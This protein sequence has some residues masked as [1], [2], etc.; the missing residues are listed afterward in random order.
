ME[1]VDADAAGERAAEGAGGTQAGG[2]AARED[3]VPGEGYATGTEV[4]QEEPIPLLQPAYFDNLI[5]WLLV[6]LVAIFLIL[7]RT[8]LPRVSGILAARAG[9]VAN[10]LA[11][12]ED[13]RSRAR[14]AE[15]AYVRALA[16]ARAEAGRI[17]AAARAAVQADL[18]R[19]LAEAEA[20]IAARA[21]E[22]R[23]VLDDIEAAAAVTVALVARD[24]A[25][26]IVRS[27]GIEAEEAQLEALIAHRAGAPA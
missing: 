3:H 24:A 22:S 4:P 9:A 20:R 17:A 19:D 6:S 5:F 11:A 12:A 16:E 7:T 2:P 23:R 25:R 26:E 10:D 27:F 15:E 13:H 21:A 18:A 8:V 1:N 14:A